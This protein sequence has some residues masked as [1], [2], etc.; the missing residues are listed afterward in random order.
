M[1]EDVTY[2]F[3]PAN[4]KELFSKALE[5]G[6]DAIIIDLEDSVHPAEKTH[7]RENIVSWFAAVN[8]DSITTKIYIRINHPECVDFIHD[9]KMLNSLV[10]ASITGIMVPK[11]ESGDTID[12]I[13][14][15]LTDKLT[16]LPF[17]GIIETAR[18]VHYSYAI[19]TSGVTRIAFGSLDY[20]LDINCQQTSDAFLYARSQ[21]VVASRVANLS[22]PIDCVTPDFFSSDT[23]SVDAQHAQSLGFGAKLCIHPKQVSIVAKVF[24]P[25]EEQKQ[26]AN[27]VIEQSK[28]NYAFQ[29]EGVMV[30]LPLI[31]QASRLLGKSDRKFK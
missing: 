10:G 31:K 11:M 7:G 21:I 24:S 20:S 25:S 17:I 26:W 27:K 22:A 6:A 28:D 14:N 30:D 8:E 23:L 5:C 4:K 2:L 9:V 3:V 13:K 29:V 1:K 19:A 18:G 15:H 12:R 16:E